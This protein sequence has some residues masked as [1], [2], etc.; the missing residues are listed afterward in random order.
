[1]STIKYAVKQ[2]ITR[3][4]KREVQE[5]YNKALA[6]SIAKVEAN[7]GIFGGKQHKY[8]IKIKAA[9][10]Q[11]WMDDYLGSYARFTTWQELDSWADETN[12]P[13]SLIINCFGRL[14]R[15]SYGGKPNKNSVMIYASQVWM[16]KP[17]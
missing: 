6:N 7:G 14:C 4:H 17:H 11:K 10:I 1:M 5:D 15:D 16:S 12:I 2:E 13:V 3:F 9:T 8:W